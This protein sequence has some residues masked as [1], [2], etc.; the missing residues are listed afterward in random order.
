PGGWRTLTHCAIAPRS[1]VGARRYNFSASAAFRRSPDR[2]FSAMHS[3]V[4][5]S[6]DRKG[7]VPPFLKAVSAKKGYDPFSRHRKR[8]LEKLQR[9][10]SCDVV[11]FGCVPIEQL[12]IGGFLVAV[13]AFVFIPCG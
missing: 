7:V 6:P 13:T 2:T 11:D 9:A 1:G 5:I 10:G 8:P 3:T 4:I 12:Q